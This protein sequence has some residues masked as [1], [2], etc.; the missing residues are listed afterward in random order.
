MSR[1]TP[2]RSEIVI[3]AQAGIHASNQLLDPRFRGDDVIRASLEFVSEMS[4]SW[5]LR[6]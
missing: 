3:P 5:V 4:H 2:N 1:E 6:R